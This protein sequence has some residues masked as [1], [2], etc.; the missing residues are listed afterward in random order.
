MLFEYDRQSGRQMEGL[1]T[2]SLEYLV[3]RLAS[4]PGE[5]CRAR[6]MILYVNSALFDLCR[7]FCDTRL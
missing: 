5:S 6:R 7:R 1:G 3:F 2:L 4:R